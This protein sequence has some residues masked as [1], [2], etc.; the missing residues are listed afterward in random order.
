MKSKFRALRELSYL[1]TTDDFQ[2]E[3]QAQVL[4]ETN[5]RGACLLLA[6]NLENAL[7]EAIM[8]LLAQLAKERQRLFEQDGVLATFSKKI[9]AASMLRITGPTTNRNLTIIRHIRNAFAHAKRP[10]DFETKE[11]GVLCADLTLVTPLPPHKNR[12]DEKA[13]LTSRLIFAASCSTL[14]WALYHYATGPLLRLRSDALREGHPEFPDYTLYL[15][16]K[17]L[18]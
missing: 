13:A 6:A 5:D 14:T 18:P 2:R 4:A 3:F 1:P 12:D 17:P 16:R 9:D 15:Q 11:I 7:D 10:I 8:S